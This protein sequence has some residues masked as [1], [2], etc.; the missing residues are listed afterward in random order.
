ME[1]HDPDFLRTFIPAIERTILFVEQNADPLFIP[2]T[3]T[4]CM[5]SWITFAT[6][7]L[8]GPARLIVRLKNTNR[9]GEMRWLP[10][11]RSR[12][13]PSADCGG[14]GK[15]RR[16]AVASTLARNAQHGQARQCRQRQFLSWRQPVAVVAP[17]ATIGFRSRWYG[18]FRTM[19]R[20][21][22]ARSSGVPGDVP[23]GEWGCGIIFWSKVTKT[24]ENEHGERRGEGHFLHASIRRIL[25]SIRSKVN[26][27]TI[28]V[29]KDNRTTQHG[30]R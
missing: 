23:P 14:V 4:I 25:A 12:T 28:C 18:T 21:G 26:I 7:R 3:W 1:Q 2:M 30:V 15:G 5:S 19:A 11:T 17:S 8:C 16:S 13:N 29:R 10:R 9:T 6:R 24:E 27:W 20:H 22:R